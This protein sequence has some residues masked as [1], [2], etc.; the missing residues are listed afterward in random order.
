MRHC[1]FIDNFLTFFYLKIYII[2]LKKFKILMKDLGVPAVTKIVNLQIGQLHHL[3]PVYTI[4]F[5]CENLIHAKY[6]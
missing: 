1:V 4:S 6:F 2:P 5:I 3:Q